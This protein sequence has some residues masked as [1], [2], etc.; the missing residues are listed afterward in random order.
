MSLVELEIPAHSVYV[1]LVRLAVA[2]L[3][4]SA[5][6]D[7][8]K[9][10][11]LKIAVSESCANAVLSTEDAGADAPITVACSDEAQGFVIEVS[12][13][14][15]RPA[16]YDGDPVDSGGFS[17]RMMMSMELM[18]SLVD[19]YEFTANESGGMSARLVMSR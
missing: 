7:E 12:D 13:H 9:V 6:I 16:F 4:R 17:S 10:D 15:G 1:G 19:R 14:S 8:E 3:A 18:K 11:D 5:G 2:S